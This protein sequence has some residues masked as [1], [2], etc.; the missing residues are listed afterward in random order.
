MAEGQHSMKPFL[1]IT[2]SVWNTVVAPLLIA[3]MM[4]MAVS[5]VMLRE[6]V[7]VLTVRVTALEQAVRERP[8]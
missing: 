1:T 4:A 2:Q 8:Q 6:Q 5:V 7:A 3:T